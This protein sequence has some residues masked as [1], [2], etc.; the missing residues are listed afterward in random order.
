L[1]QGPPRDVLGEV[2]DRNAGLGAADVGLSLKG[3][4]RDGD[5][6]IF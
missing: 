3:M 6:L 4:S 5:S 1:Q 2:L